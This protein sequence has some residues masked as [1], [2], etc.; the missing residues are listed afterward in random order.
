MTH[1]ASR[2]A[3]HKLG[4]ILGLLVIPILVLWSIYFMKAKS[5]ID[6]LSRELAG[7]EL[8]S[9]APQDD[10]GKA[11]REVLAMQIGISPDKV[12]GDIT[13]VSARIARASGLATDSEW[14]SNALAETALITLPVFDRLMEQVLQQEAPRRE[15]SL[16][17]AAGEADSLLRR[18]QESLAQ[19]NLAKDS[20]TTATLARFSDLVEGIQRTASLVESPFS[21]QTDKA[22]AIA[23]LQ[24]EYERLLPQAATLKGNVLSTLKTRLQA[25]RAAMWRNLLLLTMAGLVSALA[26]VG[27]AVL[28]MRS[29]FIALDGVEKAREEA[30][31]ARREAEQMNLR[32]STINADIS[33]L[34]QELAVKVKELRAAQ[35]ELIKKGRMEQLGQLTATIAHEIRNPLGAI[36]TSAFM[37][38]RK[39]A[40][41]GADVSGPLQRINNGVN[42]CDAIISQLLD[43]SRTKEI[44]ASPAL[45]D[46]WLVRIVRDEAKTLPEN[47]S[48]ECALGLEQ[49]QVPFDPARLQR[50]VINLLNNAC[51]AL[52]NM[53][54]QDMPKGHRHTITITTLRR[55]EMASIRVADNG[56]GM[57]ADVLQRVREPLFT[58]KS[59]GTGLG[60][61]AV[62]QIVKQHGGHLDI[63]SDVGKGAVFTINLPLLQLREVDRAA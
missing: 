35:D 21:L 52:A 11:R 44:N 24:A 42:R 48:I 10:S 47:V 1:L 49:V 57:P 7:V 5:E 14:Q 46:D 4:Q 13:V 27:L 50:A 26:G 6:G 62:E 56:P 60:I 43:F 45:L 38:Q 37:L 34:N 29:T 17:L 31:E 20:G 2:T 58:T 28:M 18:L 9:L 15:A 61:P 19:T 32:F 8:V 40:Q 22:K 25:R 23:H 53:Q 30:Q 41:L 36:R 54:E 3:A 12:V 33:N 55:D 51:E 63:A 39:T 16:M 59:F